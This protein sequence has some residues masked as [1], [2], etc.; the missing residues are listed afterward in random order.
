MSDNPG[1][2]AGLAGLLA[3]L[4]VGLAYATDVQWQAVSVSA[5]GG[6]WSIGRNTAAQGPDARGRL[7]R[8]AQVQHEL[9]GVATTFTAQVPLAH[10]GQPRGDLVLVHKG[11]GEVTPIVFDAKARDA[12]AL[13]A[14]AVCERRTP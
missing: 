6:L 14:A 12:S 8:Q 4:A 13:L 2:L 9:G 5:R 10:C 1:P 7:V 11:S 3:G